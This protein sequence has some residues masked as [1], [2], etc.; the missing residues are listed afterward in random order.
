MG[1]G[2]TCHLN[3]IIHKQ[4]TRKQL[5]ELLGDFKKKIERVY[6]QDGENLEILF[7]NGKLYLLS[8]IPL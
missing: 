2:N 6:F 7:T 1:S 3:N 8:A 5:L 4:N